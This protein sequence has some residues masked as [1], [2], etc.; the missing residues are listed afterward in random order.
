MTEESIRPI[1]LKHIHARTGWGEPL[2]PN[3]E[4]EELY[5]VDIIELPDDALEVVFKYVF[6]E[7]GFSQYP[8]THHLAGR[9]ILT[10]AGEIIER[11]LREV[12]TGVGAIKD[13][14]K[15]TE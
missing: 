9:V 12:H 4:F 11:E 8:K 7:D 2:R 1:I 14:F 10:K 5:I 15:G 6:D 3:C 13:P